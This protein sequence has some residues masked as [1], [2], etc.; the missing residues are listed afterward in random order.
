MLAHMVRTEMGE[1]PYLQI[2]V[3]EH[4]SAVGVITRIEAFLNSLSHRPALP[5]PADFDLQAVEH[6]PVG[7]QEKPDQS[8]SLYLPPLGLY[9]DSLLAL[10]RRMGLKAAPMPWAGVRNMNLGRSETGSK[11]YLPFPALLDAS[12]RTAAETEGPI[13]LLIP[14]GE[15]ADADGL[16]ARSIRSVL[17]R[18]GLDRIRLVSPTVETLLTTFPEPE[19]LFR[20]LLAGDLLYAASP[21]LREQLPSQQVPTWEELGKWAQR[22]GRC[23]RKGRFLGAV[24]TP[25][26]LTSL[27]DGILAALEAEENTILRAPLSEALWFL[28]QDRCEGKQSARLLHQL[29]DQMAELG[30]LLEERS[31]FAPGLFRL[32]EDAGRELPRFAGAN[33]RYRWAKALEFSRRCDA[34]LTLAPR[35]ENTAS[36]LD[37]RGLSDACE[38]PLFQIALDGDWEEASWAKLRSFLYYC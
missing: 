4:F 7:M 5:L 29:A 24:G 12:L 9:T 33:G 2:E 1:K 35:Y 27:E 34:V 32:Q 21:S 3:D 31:P 14:A 25:M 18:K 19:L 17:D 23:P 15:G 16:Y 37:L 13:Q 11:E 10:C 26:S 38:A 6:R 20:A 22:I 30:I 8:L 28:W 36:V